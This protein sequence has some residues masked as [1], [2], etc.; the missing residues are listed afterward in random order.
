[1]IGEEG[2]PYL[3]ITIMAKDRTFSGALHEFPASCL[4]GQCD[5]KKP[6][7]F[8]NKVRRNP[9]QYNI[10]YITYC[11]VIPLIKWRTF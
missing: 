7:N 6:F 5:G 10:I 1:M 8:V 4:K 2:I 11:C 3:G 9:Q